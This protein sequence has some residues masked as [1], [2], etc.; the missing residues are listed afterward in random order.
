MKWRMAKFDLPLDEAPVVMGILNVTP[1]SF[2]DGG[3]YQDAYHAAD[4]AFELADQGAG[5]IDI[6]GESTRPFAAPVSLTEERS[7]VLPVLMRLSGEL[8]VPISVDTRKPELARE[9]LDRGADAVNDVGAHRR[10]PAMLEVVREFGA[11]YVCM[12]MQG[13]PA[14]MQL[15]PEYAN[16]VAEIDDFFAASL[17]CYEERGIAPE[18]VALDAGF[19]FGKT[20]EHN[21]ELMRNLKRFTRHGRP[22]VLGVSKKSFI[23]RVAGVEAAAGRLA[24]SLACVCWALQAG[25]RIFRVHDVAE[26][27]Q[28]LALWRAIEPSHVPRE[29]N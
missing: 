21:V 26:T 24:G 7:R 12:H 29:S 23:G 28:A 2:S 14:T 11:G 25:V 20:A 8:N 17:A 18:Q 15:Q 4:R 16:L 13:E 19:G 3:L 1:D 10:I 27:V 9:A 5:I 22:L 6:G